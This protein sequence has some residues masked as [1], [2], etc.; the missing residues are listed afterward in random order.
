MI[1]VGEP[2]LVSDAVEEGREPLFFVSRGLEEL[3]DPDFCLF[4]I[5]DVDDSPNQADWPAIITFHLCDCFYPFF[6]PCPAHESHFEIVWNS[7]LNRPVER[8]LK[9]RAI[10]GGIKCQVLLDII[11]VKINRHLV[12]TIDLICPRNCTGQDII[13]PAA[14]MRILLGLV[15]QLLPLDESPLALFAFSDIPYDLDCACQVPMQIVERGCGAPEVG[16]SSLKDIRDKSLRCDL[17]PVPL[18]VQVFL[19]DIIPAFQY[20]V[21]QDRPPLTVERDAVF[22]IASPDYLVRGDAG[23]RLDCP[24]PCNDSSLRVDCKGR[25]GEEIEDICQAFSELRRFLLGLFQ[26][27]D[28][29]GDYLHTGDGAPLISDWR[30]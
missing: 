17:I 6:Y 20:Q 1:G 8:V 2:D 3:T 23:H 25:I 28:V 9:N 19:L 15:Q 22:V 24:V 30:V 7:L 18:D 21:D 27:G 10:F 29:G 13:L 11:G 16:T 4:F 26:A 12:N 5:R 14:H